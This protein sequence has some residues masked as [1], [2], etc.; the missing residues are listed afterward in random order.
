MK[1]H[2]SKDITKKN[3][4]I[5]SKQN[6]ERIIESNKKSYSSHQ[7]KKSENQKK[8]KALFL[9]EIKSQKERELK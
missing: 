9:K 4:K 1:K 5:N 6:S 2:N 3:F 8:Q 7:I